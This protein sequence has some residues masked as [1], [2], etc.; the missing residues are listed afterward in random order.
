MTMRMS[1]AYVREDDYTAKLYITY[2]KTGYKRIH[3]KCYN[4]IM[5]RYNIALILL[6]SS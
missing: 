1:D 6:G 3:N 2:L 5:K 4:G